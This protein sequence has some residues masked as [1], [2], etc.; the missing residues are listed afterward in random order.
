MT[1]NLSDKRLR[2]GEQTRAHILRS[3]IELI[4]GQGLKSLSTAKLAS[5]SGVSKSTIFHHFPSSD[6][7]LVSALHLIVD[8][9]KRA[10]LSG[11]YQHVEHFMQALGESLF[12]TPESSMTL[13]RAFLSYS[14]ESLFNP[15]YHALL[16]SFA[17]ELEQAFYDQLSRLVPDSVK[18]E[19]VRAASSLLLPL[20]DGMGLHYLLTGD[21]SKYKQMWSA[22]TAF[23]VQ[24][25][26]P[27]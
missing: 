6:D 2:K 22:Q 16:A 10:M 17:D 19:A 15:A 7:V 8:E 1:A 9:M 12:D 18:P 27:S 14:H 23:L 13:F 20:M 4:A 5:A 26:Q 3:A 11:S 25:L 21:D 24:M